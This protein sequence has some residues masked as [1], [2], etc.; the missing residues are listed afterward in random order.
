MIK[1]K[2]IEQ[3]LQNEVR[4]PAEVGT[5]DAQHEPKCAT[6][7]GRGEADDH[8]GACTVDDPGQQIAPELVRS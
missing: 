8:G 2:N 5:A 7:Q 6:H 1:G 3:A 4:A